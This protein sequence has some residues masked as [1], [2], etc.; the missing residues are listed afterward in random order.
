M[1]TRPENP[2]AAIRDRI[3]ASEGGTARRRHAKDMVNTVYTFFSMCADLAI[4]AAGFLAAMLVRFGEISQMQFYNLLGTWG[5]FSI[6]TLLLSDMESVYYARTSVN[7]SM[8]AFR[9]IRIALTVVTAYVVVIFTFRLPVVFFIHSRLVIL[10]GLIFWLVTAVVVRV[11]L[12]PRLI[13]WL[14]RIGVVRFDK[15]S[16]LACGDPDILTR[17]KEAVHSSPL[18]HEVI[19]FVFC[20]SASCLADPAARL[21]YYRRRLDE[22]GCDDLCIAMDDADFRTIANFI[23]RCRQ[24]GIAISFYSGLFENMGYFDPWLSF[25]DK[26]AVVFFT[27]PMSSFSER[28]WRF[29]DITVSATLLVLL[30]PLFLLLALAIKVSSP[31]PVLFRQKRVG[32][33]EKPFVFFKFRSMRNDM[34]GN[35]EAH[36]EYFERYVEGKPADGDVGDRFKAVDTGRITTVGRLMRRTSLDELPQLWNVLRG[37]MSLVGPRPCIPYELRYY[38][39]WHRIRFT[40]KPGLTGIWQVYGRSRLPFDAAQFLDFCYALKRS[41]GLN[42]R[43]ILKTFPVMLF[44]RGGL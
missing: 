17:V 30:L 35:I 3:P 11:F 10:L 22:T 16:I 21:D 41:I 32:L 29:V 8:L 34:R 43:L 25:V 24:E 4:L 15:V 7:R 18:Y 42:T 23:F 36:S 12:M 13:V 9:L 14:R 33:G 27:P 40:V 20:E 2:A 5:V 31:G 38:K 37:E 26:P 6:A 44:G 39:D 1:S 28:A 19:D